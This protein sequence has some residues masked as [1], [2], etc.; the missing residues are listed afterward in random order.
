MDG[1]EGSSPP[2]KPP[3]K[4]VGFKGKRVKAKFTRNGRTGAQQKGGVS[5]QR[6][7]QYVAALAAASPPS[8]TV[9]A[10]AAATSNAAISSPTKKEFK[11][12]LRRHVKEL[13]RLTASNESQ[14]KKNT[15]L[16]RKLVEKEE[17]VKAAT[18][19]NSLN[20]SALKKA[21]KANARVQV[22]LNREMAFRQEDALIAQ[23]EAAATAVAFEE[24]RQ[25]YKAALKY[26]QE[27]FELY[28]KQSVDE[29]K[30]SILCS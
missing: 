18:R 23:A 14:R 15:S 5:R 12:A 7:R 8:A 3:P 2:S 24:E 19:Q 29:A 13:R 17:T 22:A 26:Q 9:R 16:K 6:H 11:A 30:V 21:E 4:T 25:Q 20:K 27:E 10:A 28:V 1:E